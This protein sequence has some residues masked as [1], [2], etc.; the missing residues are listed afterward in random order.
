MTCW[1]TTLDSQV[2]ATPSAPVAIATAIMPSTSHVSSV[3][4]SF[5]IASSRTSR[6]RNG[7][8]MLMPALSA[9][10]ASTAPSAPR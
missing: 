2:C 1:P 10:S 3:V 7:E 4:S 8:T 9:I 5:G 6:S